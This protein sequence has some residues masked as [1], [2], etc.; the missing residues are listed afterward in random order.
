[1]V[2]DI[3]S[4]CVA[5]AADHVV[6]GFKPRSVSAIMEL[7]SMLRSCDAAWQLEERFIWCSDAAENRAELPPPKFSVAQLLLENRLLLSFLTSIS[8]SEPV[9]TRVRYPVVD[10]IQSVDSAVKEYHLPRSGGDGSALRYQQ[11]WG[12]QRTGP[13]ELRW[14]LLAEYPTL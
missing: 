13:D 6:N 10:I 7:S 2:K 12:D 3:S 5:V 1:M 14:G 8:Y 9:L 4:F 11:K